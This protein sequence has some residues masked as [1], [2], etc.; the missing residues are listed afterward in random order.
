MSKLVIYPQKFAARTY[1]IVPLH[2]SIRAHR[3]LHVNV[4][5]YNRTL[6]A[7]IR[8]YYAPITDPTDWRPGRGYAFPITFTM[9]SGER[10]NVVE[11]L[12][13][14][15]ERLMDDYDAG[16]LLIPET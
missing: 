1:A 12:M 5:T 11:R 3:A 6:R 4:Q 15:L 14:A 8:E 13:T 10:V 16:R 9:P 2:P 7:H